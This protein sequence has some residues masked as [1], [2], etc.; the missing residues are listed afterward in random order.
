GQCQALP[1]LSYPMV[2][3]LVD[4][5]LQEWKSKSVRGAGRTALAQLVVGA[6]AGARDRATQE[7]VTQQLSQLRQQANTFYQLLQTFRWEEG[8]W[9]AGCPPHVTELSPITHIFRTYRQLVQGKLRFFFN[10]L[11]K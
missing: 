11:C 10:D 7:C 8:P 9:E 5:R 1:A 4:F 6:A 3:P 2:L